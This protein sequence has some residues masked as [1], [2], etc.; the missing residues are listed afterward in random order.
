MKAKLFHV[1][2]ILAMLTLAIVPAVSAAPKAV[3]DDPEFV[4]KVDNRPDPLTAQLR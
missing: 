4:P 2:L 1:V 3:I